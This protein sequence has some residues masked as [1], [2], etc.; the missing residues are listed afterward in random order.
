MTVT[1]KVRKQD[2]VNGQLTVIDEHDETGDVVAAITK[3]VK[4][5]YDFKD[6]PHFIIV[7][8]DGKFHDIDIKECTMVRE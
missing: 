5:F 3:R 8:K 1:F 2:F 6:E 7:D 4:A